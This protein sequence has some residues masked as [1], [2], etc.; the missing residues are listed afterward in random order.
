MRAKE[1]LKSWKFC[2]KE[3]KIFVIGFHKTGG[4][5]L[6]HLFLKNL[7]Q[8]R[9]QPNWGFTLGKD[10]RG[11]YWH[12]FKC[13]SDG[14]HKEDF[15][16]FAT[17][18]PNSLFILNCR[19]IKDWLFSRFKHGFFEHSKGQK[20]SLYPCSSEMLADWIKDNQKH[21][22]DVI[23]YF[24]TKPEQLI[25]ID[26]SQVNWIRFLCEHSGLTAYDLHSN[27][28]KSSILGNTE[29]EHFNM[30]VNKACELLD[31]SIQDL[32]APLLLPT[33]KN[34]NLTQV[35]SV[36]KNNLPE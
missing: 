19:P 13:F 4:T 35:M 14:G 5:T 11:D 3:G 2:G 26:I 22:I 24:S 17:H 29:L 7:L 21:H 25:I 23:E 8:A 20:T 18:Y 1:G 33:S 31:V 27:K 9:H 16:F 6:H 28:R 15:R 36:I 12:K 10:R 34:N 30:S 32:D